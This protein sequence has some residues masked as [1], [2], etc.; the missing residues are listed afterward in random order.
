MTVAELIEH[1]SK[2]PQQAV[3]EVPW[4]DDWNPVQSIDV[5]EARWVRQDKEFGDRVRSRPSEP[6]I[7]QIIP[8]DRPGEPFLLELDE[9]VSPLCS[10][11]DL[12]HGQIV[13]LS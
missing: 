11:L 3:V 9:R 12:P 13:Q 10:E 8:L 4:R 1:L 2:L 6:L 7:T 5:V